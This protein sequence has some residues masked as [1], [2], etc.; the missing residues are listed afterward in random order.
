MDDVYVHDFCSRHGHGH[1]H[2]DDIE[3]LNKS[4]TAIPILMRAL[5]SFNVSREANSS[6][7]KRASDLRTVAESLHLLLLF[8]QE[9]VPLIR[10]HGGLD[11]AIRTLSRHSQ[12]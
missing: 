6:H 7:S 3:L 1:G 10:E 8:A 5:N 2:G 11:F 9:E 4:R 12:K